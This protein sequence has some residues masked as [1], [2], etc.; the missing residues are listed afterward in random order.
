MKK[1]KGYDYIYGSKVTIQCQAQINIEPWKNQTEYLCYLSVIK[2]DNVSDFFRYWCK[3]RRDVTC[4]VDEPP[5]E[6][7]DSDV[8][9]IVGTHKNAYI[10]ERNRVLSWSKNIDTKGSIVSGRGHRKQLIQVP[11]ETFCARDMC[12]SFSVP[13]YSSS[14]L[15]KRESLKMPNPMA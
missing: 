10:R 11:F 14:T 4:V 15:N 13:K 9:E 3:L 2:K 6:E 1:E 8:L 5:H 7:L 12:K